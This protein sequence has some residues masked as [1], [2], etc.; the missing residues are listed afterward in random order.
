MSVRTFIER[1]HLGRRTEHEVAR[2]IG[3]SADRIRN[4]D[5]GGIALFSRFGAFDHIVVERATRVDDA[6]QRFRSDPCEANR[7]WLVTAVAG[8]HEAM[9]LNVL[10]RW[11][12]LPR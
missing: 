10:A 8:M 12:A 1:I 2:A 3:G 11:W 4:R 5:A 6:I 7:S 9:R